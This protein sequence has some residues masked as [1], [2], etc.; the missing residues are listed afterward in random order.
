MG[1]LWLLD[2]IAAVALLDGC[3]IGGGNFFNSE[4]SGVPADILRAIVFFLIDTLS[5]HPAQLYETCVYLATS[6]LMFLLCQKR[7]TT[8]E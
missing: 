7:R 6:L 5:R 8:L 3:L 1:Y 2:R 4:I